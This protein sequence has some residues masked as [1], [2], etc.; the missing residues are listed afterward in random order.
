MS[1]TIHLLGRPRLE[2]STGEAYRFRSRKSWALLAFLILNDHPPTRSQLASLL[3]ADADDPLR[4]LRW[5]LSEIRRGLGDEGSLDGDPV[6]LHLEDTAIDV[7]VVARGSWQDAVGLPDLGA[8]LLDGV[9]IRGVPA[10]ESWL[11]SQQRHVA[12][13]TEAIL[14]EAAIGSTSTGETR[15]ALDYA[16]RASTLSPTDENHQALLIRLYRLL[17]DDVAAEEQYRACAR[18]LA[19]E[20]G[21]APGPAVHAA[22]RETRL[23]TASPADPASVA[24]IL[25]AGSAAVAAGA[26]EA[27]VQSL[28]TAVRLADATDGTALR[29]RS[30]VVLGEALI[31]SLRGHDEEGM[32][33]L[34]QAHAIAVEVGDATAVAHAGAELGY[35][36]FLRARYERAETWLTAAITAAAGSASI[37]AKAT[38][39]LGSVES[40]L[41][42]YA[43]ALG[44]L[45][46]ACDLAR[47]TGDPRREAYGRS[48][49]GRMA[50]L[51]GHL[52]LAAEH[53]DAS[54]A[55][56]EGDHWLALVPWPQALR[57][58]VQLARGDTGGATLLLDQAFAR[59]CQLGDPCWEGTAARGLAMVAD[60]TDDHDRA[61]ALLAEARTR[62]NRLA[63]PYVWLDCHILD[64]QC[65]VG[66]RHGHVDTAHWIDA[67]QALAAR[68]GMRELIVRSLLHGAALGHD[69]D[70]RAAALMAADIDNPLLHARFDG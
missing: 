44:H 42:N 49:L 30:R 70:A 68:T 14:H 3:F 12:G 69:G 15:A 50:L 18:V 10:F 64:A 4:A 6:V 16:I 9:A 25:E 51:P 66:L 36:D 55:L 39:Y 27:G 61:F 57:G 63:D 45:A 22:L 24:A 47:A 29:I 41:G 5:S 60:A 46:T 48:M 40:D 31:H 53:L 26:V 67:M 2:R 11:L 23:R 1:L 65:E 32:A 13:T 8:T 59:A 21:I 20:L 38:G 43:V 33:A 28:R 52:D 37:I 34:H 56:A 19:A 62:C 17:G 54:I 58:E 7:R 35:V